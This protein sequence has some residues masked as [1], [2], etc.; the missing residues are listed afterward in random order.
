MKRR[1]IKG[2]AG[3]PGLDNN[4]IKLP[5]VQVIR[6]QINNG[7]TPISEEDAQNYYQL[8]HSVP[9]EEPW[10]SKTV[11]Y[12]QNPFDI[13]S[14]YVQDSEWAPNW[15]KN[16]MPYA[17]F[18][19]SLAAGK[20]IIPKVHTTQATVSKGGNQLSPA[21]KFDERFY[22]NR[23]VNNYGKPTKDIT[24]GTPQE[25]GEW[26]EANPYEW[27]ET[28]RAKKLAR[29]NTEQTASE[30]PTEST[31]NTTA[32][33]RGRLNQEALAKRNAKYV[34]GTGILPV[35]SK[36]V[37]QKYLGYYFTAIE[38]KYNQL[39]KLYNSYDPKFQAGA[40]YQ[41][42]QDIRRLRQSFDKECKRVRELGHEV[43]VPEALKKI[44]Y[45]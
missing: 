39:L 43:N 11:R 16:I 44:M 8:E 25:T 14:D 12:V 45:R 30:T 15:L 23:S 17:S 2:Q 31:T 32:T 26:V 40:K 37:A 33:T 41:A 28:A 1:I 34:R 3:I 9:Y 5:E 13:A 21:E 35:T 29:E 6:R 22:N 24:S 38:D 4:Y 27:K 20:T 18:G 19:A 10:W 36:S 7:L 42:S